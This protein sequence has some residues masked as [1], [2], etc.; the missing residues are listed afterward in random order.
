MCIILNAHL[1]QS[2]RQLR[3]EPAPA[4]VIDSTP[5]QLSLRAQARQR[6]LTEK[7]ASQDT[8]PN[9]IPTEIPSI[10]SQAIDQDVLLDELVRTRHNR[11]NTELFDAQHEENNEDNAPSPSV[12]VEEKLEDVMT[13]KM[14]CVNME[15]M[16]PD[17]IE[18]ILASVEPD[19]M[20]L[21]EYNLADGEYQWV[22]NWAFTD[23][24]ELVLEWA[25]EMSCTLLSTYSRSRQR[26]SSNV[27]KWSRAST[28]TTWSFA[29]LLWPTTTSTSSNTELTRRI[30]R[31]EKQQT[32]RQKDFSSHCSACHTIGSRPSR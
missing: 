24:I 27:S 25:K 4:A 8:V 23:Q 29:T 2:T 16:N 26:K 9:V 1:F 5:T 13:K 6:K 32:S 7:E 3:A 12:I 14:S 30:R 11:L 17:G 28:R 20:V 18:H 31:Q 22:L 19:D 21:P 10:L 15:S